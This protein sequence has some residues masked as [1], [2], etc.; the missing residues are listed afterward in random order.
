MTV[1]TADKPEKVKF[2][3]IITVSEMYGG[4]PGNEAEKKRR[5]REK[6]TPRLQHWAPET[7]GPKKNEGIN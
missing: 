3:Y 2:R 7:N 5:E 1:D 4:E 6:K